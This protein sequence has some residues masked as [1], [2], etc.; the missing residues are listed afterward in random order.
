MVEVLWKAVTGL[1]NQ[2]LTEAIKFHDV[3]HR[4]RAS[5]GTGT[6]SLEASLLQQLTAMREAVLFEVFLDLQKAYVTMDWDRFLE[7][8]A[9]YGVGPRAIQL[10]QTYWD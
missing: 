4:F 10:L 2:R 6:A 8:V 3:L 1:L 9:A 7:S 5:R